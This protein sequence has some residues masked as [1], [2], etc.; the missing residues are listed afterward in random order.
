MPPQRWTQG[1][2]REELPRLLAERKMSQRELARRVG[3]NQSY[4]TFVLQ[5]RRAPSRKLLEG[6][7]AAIDLHVEYFREFREAVVIERLRADPGVVDRL[8]RL[9]MRGRTEGD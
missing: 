4:L 5:G 3:V 8:Y 6:T 9:V 1:S 2:F 7:A